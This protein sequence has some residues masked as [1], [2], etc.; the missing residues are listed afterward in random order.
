M[1]IDTNPLYLHFL[2]CIDDLD[3]MICTI[4]MI[5]MPT[6]LKVMV[7]KAGEIEASSS[8]ACSSLNKF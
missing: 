6:L 5:L 8:V 7:L 3:M 4:F 1:I 2:K